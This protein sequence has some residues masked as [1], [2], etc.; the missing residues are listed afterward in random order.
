VVL[1]IILYVWGKK[2]KSD[3][4]NY[5]DGIM[6]SGKQITDYFELTGECSVFACGKENIVAVNTSKTK[7]GGHVAWKDQYYSYSPDQP[8]AILAWH[9]ASD[10][11]GADAYSL[12]D[13]RR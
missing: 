4:V 11:Y 12:D 8:S 5:Q 2:G 3:S 13:F 9:L 10:V 6:G 1:L 7:D